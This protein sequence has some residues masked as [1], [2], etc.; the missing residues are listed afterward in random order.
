METAAK[1]FLLE[2]SKEKCRKEFSTGKTQGKLQERVFYW[3]NPRKT[4]GKS[5][6]L[7]KRKEICRK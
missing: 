1:S 6:L 3:K 4:A 5:F 7:E 2:K